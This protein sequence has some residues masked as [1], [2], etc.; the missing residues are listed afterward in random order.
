MPTLLHLCLMITAAVPPHV[1]DPGNAGLVHFSSTVFTVVAPSGWVLDTESGLMQGL[2]AVFYPEGGRWRGPVVM[3][4]NSGDRAIAGNGTRQQFIEN[5]V[6]H[7]RTRHPG[8]KIEDA[9]ALP[10][11]NGT[12]VAVKHFLGGQNGRYEA[13]A[14]IEEEKAV[15]SIIFSARTKAAFQK[16]YAAFVSLVK[17]YA[18]ITDVVL[19]Q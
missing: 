3:Y 14:Y 10:V 7:F 12:P 8:I 6:T 1:A 11:A 9:K 17:S 15:N 5:E 2:P 4:V 19:E 18:F 13:V 16:H